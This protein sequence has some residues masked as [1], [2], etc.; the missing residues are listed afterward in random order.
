MK[1]MGGVSVSMQSDNI[2]FYLRGYKSI[3]TE[4]DLLLKRTKE[5]RYISDEK[6]LALVSDLTKLENDVSYGQFAAAV[7]ASPFALNTAVM[8][9][10]TQFL[11]LKNSKKLPLILVLT[12]LL[13]GLLGVVV[14][15][16]RKGVENNRA[17]NG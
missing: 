17:R 6:Y 2:P 12:L 14:V 8:E 5:Q 9:V 1:N 10:D 13:G 7:E 15:L 16:V 3:E 11:E 4:R